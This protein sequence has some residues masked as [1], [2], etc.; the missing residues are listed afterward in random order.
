MGE[1]PPESRNESTG[2]R[3]VDLIAMVFERV[4]ESLRQVEHALHDQ[5]DSEADLIG[6]IGDHVFASGGKR[7]RP[8]LC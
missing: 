7:L 4:A 2:Q 8:I 3:A 5:L 1:H 6:T